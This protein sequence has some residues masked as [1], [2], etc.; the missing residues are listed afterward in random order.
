VRRAVVAVLTVA[1]LAGLLMFGSYEQWADNGM[2]GVRV[3]W[4]SPW[5]DRRQGPDGV[6]W[7]V[8]LAT[9]SGAL[10]AAGVVCLLGAWRLSRLG[11]RPPGAKAAEPPTAADPGRMSAFR[12]P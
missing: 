2:S 7:E 12:D 4:P 5:Y 6:Q 10:G 1:G 8:N 9:A 3:G 11:R